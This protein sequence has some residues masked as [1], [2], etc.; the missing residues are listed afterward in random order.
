MPFMRASVIANTTGIDEMSGALLKA[1][2]NELG[3][4]LADLAGAAGMTRSGIASTETLA[5]VNPKRAVTYLTALRRAAETK[6][7]DEGRFK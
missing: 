7:G 6:V 4:S 3:L 5:V 1:M 2:R